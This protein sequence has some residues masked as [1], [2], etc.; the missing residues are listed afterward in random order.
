MS[1][2]FQKSTSIW[3]RQAHGTEN[4]LKLVLH[5]NVLDNNRQW[6][7]QVPP[8]LKKTLKRAMRHSVFMPYYTPEERKQMRKKAR[9]QM[10]R[11]DFLE[12]YCD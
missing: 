12:Y 5:W 7:Y 9:R 4:E 3:V 6:K 1:K 10:H 8:D 11:Q 2:S